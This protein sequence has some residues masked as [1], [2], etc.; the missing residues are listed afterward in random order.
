MS[1]KTMEQIV[2]EKEEIIA[3]ATTTPKK[4]PMPVGDYQIN[5]LL[6]QGDDADEY[7][8]QMVRMNAAPATPQGTNY[9]P[10]R[11]GS[12]TLMPWETYNQNPDM[13]PGPMH[14]Y[15]GTGWFKICRNTILEDDMVSK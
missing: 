3:K 15:P 2:K 12:K 10:N 8:E 1:G 14:N 5:R 7:M 13:T 4:E 9:N 6:E 11:P